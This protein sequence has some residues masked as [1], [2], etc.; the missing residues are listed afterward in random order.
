[1]LEIIGNILCAMLVF[2][3]IG[4]IIMA[5]SRAAAPSQRIAEAGDTGAGHQ[6]TNEGASAARFILGLAM[7]AAGA[8][9][10]YQIHDQASGARKAINDIQQQADHQR[11]LLYQQF[12]Q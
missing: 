5:L 8:F 12:G 4:Q 10:A 2:A 11:E 7:I 9:F 3:G 6:N 1:M